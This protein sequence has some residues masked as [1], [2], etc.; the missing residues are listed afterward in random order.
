M[1]KNMLTGVLLRITTL[2]LEF[3]MSGERRRGP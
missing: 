1:I 2:W 3:A